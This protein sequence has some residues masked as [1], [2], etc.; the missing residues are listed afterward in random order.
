MHIERQER[1]ILTALPFRKN[2]VWQ[3][4]IVRLPSSHPAAKSG[5][6]AVVWS[7]ASTGKTNEFSGR[8]KESIGT[9]DLILSFIALAKDKKLGGY[10]PAK[11][12]V[13]TAAHAAELMSTLGPLGIEVSAKPALAVMDQTIADWRKKYMVHGRDLYAGRGM[14]RAI[15]E[16]FADS[17]RAL[18][19]SSLETIID[20]QAVFRIAPHPS[21]MHELCSVEVLDDG[22][23]SASFFRNAARM[24]EC[25]R[26]RLEKDRDARK[27]SPTS[28]WTVVAVPRVA[29]GPFGE[30]WDDLDLAALPRDFIAT[31]I[32]ELNPKSAEVPDAR[33]AES[34]AT[35]LAALA[36]TTAGD[37]AA[38]EWRKS[39]T[40]GDQRIEL[41]IDLPEI[42]GKIAGD[43]HGISE[44]FR[45]NSE[46]I[47][48]NDLE[49]LES[50]QRTAKIEGR[51]A[52]A[53]A[54]SECIASVASDAPP[55]RLEAFRRFVDAQLLD[56]VVRRILIERA[57]AAD[58]SF[59]DAQSFY[60]R[61]YV[62]PTTD[63]AAWDALA[64]RFRRENDIVRGA[65][66]DLDMSTRISKRYMELLTARADRSVRRAAIDEAVRDLL[67]IRRACPSDFGH[68]RLDAVAMLIELGR[69]TEAA[70]ILRENFERGST[71]DLILSSLLAFQAGRLD[72]ARSE[73]ASWVSFVPDV[74]K[75]L[76]AADTSTVTRRRISVLTRKNNVFPHIV[77]A[78]LS[79]PNAQTFLRTAFASSASTSS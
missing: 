27:S 79:V 23:Y 65:V 51:E 45:S 13:R 55:G 63:P 56:G 8:A 59:V 77:A 19:E 11:L 61:N 2:E 34:I 73:I 7:I 12:Q 75:Y 47:A 57:M 35:I 53:T 72:Q 44:D 32:D 78:W 41:A 42:D 6:Y 26:L 43:P 24:V 50:L 66:R 37:I 33:E 20:G 74:W 46:K 64:A 60:L 68:V 17:V 54:L 4:D 48:R 30:S 3:G 1:A 71:P 15:L 67:E 21:I 10:I 58:P 14:T 39:V 16:R 9:D 62:D 29:S 40:S 22:G 18:I 76:T 5:R 52:D 70:D 31:V 28:A 25:H 38:V 36:Q 49:I 69:P